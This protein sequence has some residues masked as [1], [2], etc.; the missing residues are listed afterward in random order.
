MAITKESKYGITFRINVLIVLFKSVSFFFYYKMFGIFRDY[1]FT[2][3]TIVH[4]K[5][6]LIS[7]NVQMSNINYKIAFG[8]IRNSI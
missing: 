4:L 1:F 7:I 5:K 3:S 8:I 2:R 6:K